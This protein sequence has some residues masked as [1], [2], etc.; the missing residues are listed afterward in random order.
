VKT[1]AASLHHFYNSEGEWK[2]LLQPT[3][4]YTIYCFHSLAAIL[5]HYYNSEGEWKP[6]LQPTPFYTI[7][8]FHSLAAI[9]HHYYNSE[10]EW[11]PLLPAY[12]ILQPWRMVKSKPFID[13]LNLPV[14]ELNSRILTQPF[15]PSDPRTQTPHPSKYNTLEIEYTNI[16]FS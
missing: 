2:P 9:L 4:F 1:L 13:A 6:L 7:Y 16:V 8:C 10:G 11:K 3:P 12:I 14:V 15:P 5:H